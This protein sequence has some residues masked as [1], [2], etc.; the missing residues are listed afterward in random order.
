MGLFIILLTYPVFLAAH[1]Y[2]ISLEVVSILPSVNVTSVEI[3]T[4]KRGKK[5]ERNI[6]R[7]KRNVPEIFKG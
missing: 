1:I 6:F 4:R 2:A 3:V 7:A 5:D